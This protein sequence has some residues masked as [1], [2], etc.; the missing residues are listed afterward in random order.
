[1]RGCE[2]RRLSNADLALQEESTGP[3]QTGVEELLDRVQLGT[4]A[5][6]CFRRR[7]NRHG[8]NLRM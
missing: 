8:P 1:M 6:D 4:P 5:D 2:Q 3:L 7:C